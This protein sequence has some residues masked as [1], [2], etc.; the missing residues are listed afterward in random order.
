MLKNHI[1]I[2]LR[3]L[4]KRKTF[5]V[6][7]ILGLAL[8][9]ASSIII[10][11]FIAH[12][13]SFDKF[14]SN[15]ARIY[16]FVTEEHMDDVGFVAAVPPGF[17]SAFETNYEFA[18][19]T[20]RR[21]FW[22][23]QLINIGSPG[24]S[25]RQSRED[26]SF[27]EAP[28]FSIFNYPLLSEISGRTLEEPNTAY[29]TQDAALRMF[30]TND[31]LGKTFV[32]ENQETIEIIGI[33]KTL[34]KTTFANESLFVSFPSIKNY[35]R[36][37]FNES[38]DGIDS[39]LECFTLLK[40]NQS[41]VNIEKVLTEL[42]KQ[43]R[44]DSKNKHIY[45][46]QEMT[47]VHLDHRYGGVNVQLLWVFGTIGFFLLGIACINFI[48]IATAQGFKRSKEVGIRKVLG[49]LK[50]H[51][52]WQFISET[53][54][55]SLLGLVLGGIFA[56]VLL[57]HFTNL[58][59]LKLS[60]LDTIDARFVGFL[61]GLLFLV[62]FISGSYPGLLLA[63]VVP[64]LA[65]KGKLGQNDTGGERTRKVLVIAQF[66]VSI[67]L[68][69]AT[70]VIGKQ[71]R[72]AI[73]SDL[74]FDKDAIVMVPLPD[75]VK[76]P[77]LETLRQRIRTTP[78]IEEVTAC[79]A[80]PGPSD[81]SWGTSIRFDNRPETEDFS[82]AAKPADEHYISTFGL[83]LLAGRNF[84][85][86]D[87]L[88]ETLVNMAL[89]KRLGLTAPEEIVGKTLY[90]NGGTIATKIVGVVSDFHDLGF[91]EEISP[92]FIA[93]VPWSYR[94]LGLKMSL[95][96]VSATLASVKD[97][98]L[99]SFPGYSF[100]Y[101]FLDDQIAN[102]YQAENRL[103]TLSRIFSFLTLFIGSL[104][105]YGLISFFVGQRLREIGIRKVLGSSAL[106]IV[107]LFASD[108]IKLVGIS[109]LVAIPMAWSLMEIWLQNYAYRISINFWVF[110]FAL[111]SV[112]VLTL[113]I[114]TL[115]T[116]K[117]ATTSPIKSI[118]TE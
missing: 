60:F 43:H 31:V 23:E 35:S 72:F 11:L 61:L 12:H 98:Y 36:F 71:L 78:G 93:P 90:T 103:L 111:L 20:S 113:F 64:V 53:F 1:K 18:E 50:N 65:I 4:F 33:L 40:P 26:I 96:S 112:L 9:F 106:G 79:L 2:A 86:R 100:D 82:I 107:H 46:L 80:G 27:V 24:T 14:H 45:K 109:A 47:E 15:T 30:Q 38:W 115:Q 22:E 92:V 99:S 104:G 81:F 59:Q 41:V 94:K 58:F 68:I 116:L 69:V 29:I 25:L 21:I 70:L 48:N 85:R 56:F 8:G 34:P 51:L 91:E 3:T 17:K 6:I 10:Y 117:A 57:P 55:L 89:V 95:G 102:E 87:S 77:V 88:D 37:I 5:T 83:D 49:S 54:I 76:A 67:I 32:L 66:V 110:F 101:T 108:F 75:G 44:P 97:I 114:I 42:P 16:R 105:L 118:R 28:F 13:L 7:N 19:K 39:N 74:G 63:R 84:I 62:S 52:F 73:N